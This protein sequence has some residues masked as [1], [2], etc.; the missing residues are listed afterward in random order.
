MSSRFTSYFLRF[1][2][3]G[4]V[5]FSAFSCNQ[6]QEFKH[7]EGNALGT[8]FSIIYD[9]SI[10][11]SQSIDSLFNVVNASLSTYHPNSLISKINNGDSLVRVDTHFIRVFNKAKRINKETDTY[12]DPS[13]GVLVNAWGF[14]PKKAQEN[15]D[16][17]TVKKLM[18]YVGFEKITLKNKR[19]I[20]KYPEIFI[21]F[22]AIAKGYSVDVLGRFLESK[23]IVNYMVEIG[24]EVRVRG[25][26]PRGKSWVIGIEKPLT[27]GSR[28]YETT[29]SLQ[30][31]AMATSGNYRKFKIDKQG[32]KFVHTINSKTGF[33]AQNDLLSVT[34]ISTKDCADTDAYAT[35][36]MAMGYKKTKAFLQKHRE[37]Q[38]VLIYV[39]EQ[40]EVQVEENY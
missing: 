28:A 21:D 27:D 15:L 8:T 26:N 10:N 25:N 36:F 29:I 23:N 11:Y 38:T 40:G 19:I 31:K 5:L 6:P 18:K 13:V 4:L 33:T 37:L 32:R 24:G 7:L 22:N 2:A 3:S 14:G 1:I 17:L 9:D 12:F 30:N 35:A 20:K 16:S 34:V 39:N